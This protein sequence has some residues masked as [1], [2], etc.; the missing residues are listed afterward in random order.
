MG[1]STSF[2]GP[3][4]VGRQGLVSDKKFGIFLCEN[5]VG[6]HRQRGRGRKLVGLRVIVIVRMMVVVR[7]RIVVA[8][9]RQWQRL[10]LWL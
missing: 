10:L 2:N 9:A 7:V 3:D 5:V 4:L 1:A 6:H 8:V